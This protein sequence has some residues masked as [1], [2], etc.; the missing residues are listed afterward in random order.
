MSFS[1]RVSGGITRTALRLLYGLSIKGRNEFDQALVNVESVQKKK[2]GALL[3]LGKNTDAA[4][5][6]GLHPEM[7]YSEFSDKM[8]VTT[9]TDWENLVL[10]Q[11]KAQ[12]GALTQ[13]HCER[14][15][16]TSG[17]SSK[18]KWI[19]YTPSFLKELDQAISPLLVNAFQ[20]NPGIFKGKHYWSLSW[21]PTHLRTKI[22]PDA[23]DDIKLLPWWK[24]VFM[25]L[26][27][28]VPTEVSFAATSEGS[29][30]ASLACL[31]ACKDLS[32]MSV[33]SPTFSINMFEQMA[34]HKDELVRILRQGS[35]GDRQQELFHV[36][37]PCSKS[38]AD[39]LSR[40][41]GDVSPE[42]VKQIWPDMALVSSWDTS[43]SRIW[44][45][46]LK[47]LFPHAGFLGKGL[48]AT[49]GVVTIPYKDKY[50]LAVN[51][52]F[53][54]FLDPV[55]NTIYPPWGLKKGQVVKPL[56]STGS[57]FFR[58]DLNDQVRV[59]DFIENCPCLEFLG[60]VEGIDMTG[61]KLTPDIASEIIK[62]TADRF[63]IKALALVATS[64]HARDNEKPRYNLLCENKKDN[65]LEKQVARFAED[66]LGESFHYKLAA[67]IGQLGQLKAIFHPECR[68]IYQKRNENRG[69]ILGDMKIEPLVLWNDNDAEYMQRLTGES[70]VNFE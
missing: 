29:M 3:T 13:E 60:R 26:T 31:A 66:L 67:E 50:P 6:Y 12:N 46:E 30:I 17:S 42:F 61:E 19:P 49:E 41:N 1:T 47:K 33:W 22:S 35:W 2:L 38:A 64:G 14:Y 43:S 65:E 45:G 37:C 48:W 18:M 63:G 55:T 15:Q 62:K 24:R 51:S 16:P 23:N 68:K 54:E 7:S 21:I 57:G 4:L 32:L 36:P 53:Y 34:R 40:W 69:M 39:V 70:H 58:Y 56:L 44:A 27:M 25:S 5:K 10:E 8:P 9:Y 52:H 11:K 20:K 59:Y 28:A